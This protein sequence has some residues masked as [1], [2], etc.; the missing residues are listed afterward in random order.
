LNNRDQIEGIKKKYPAGTR[1]ELLSTM[2]DTHGVEK[3]TKETIT[4][5]DDIGTIHMKWDNGRG[6][7][8]ITCE[9]SF[10]VLYRPEEMKESNDTHSKEQAEGM[11]G[12]SL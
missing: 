9:D 4:H 2:N 11:G 7:G 10:R 1:I 5:V 8:L 12:M 6:L 3:G